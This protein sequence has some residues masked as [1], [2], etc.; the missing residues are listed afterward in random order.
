MKVLKLYICIHVLS[1]EFGSYNS[2]F[3]KWKLL[4]KIEAVS[5]NIEIPYG[6]VYCCSN[7]V[8]DIV[9]KN[10]VVHNRKSFLDLILGDVL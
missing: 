5:E 4:V 9:K 6:I 10:S 2:R 1:A 3:K 7:V 8:Q